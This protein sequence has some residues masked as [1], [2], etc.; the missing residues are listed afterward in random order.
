MTQSLILLGTVL[1]PV[2]CQIDVNSFNLNLSIV[3][4]H[5][6]NRKRGN[7]QCCNPRYEELKKS[8]ISLN[9]HQ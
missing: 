8:D 2:I 5:N 4:M 7:S 1:N 3:Y 6:W 9:S